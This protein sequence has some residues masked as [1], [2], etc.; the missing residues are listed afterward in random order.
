MDRLPSPMLLR[1]AA[2]PTG[3]GYVFEPKWDGF[4]AIVSTQRGH[5]KVR[6]RRGWE[7]SGLVPELGGLPRGCV[8]D[9]ELV[10]FGDDG[11][12]S[13]PRVCQRVLH[14]NAA[15]PVMFIAFDVL[16]EPGGEL[17][18]HTYSHRRARLEALGI[19][20]AHWST[21]P[22]TGD[23]AMLWQWVCDRGLEGVVAKRVGARYYPGQ[24]RWLK[25]KNRDYWRYPS[26][27]EAAA[28][29][30]TRT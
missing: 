12:P 20:G 21:T 16:A 3:P 6:S 27:L 4:R 25:V 5:P 15:I 11:L 23:G 8:F 30:W 9:G 2:L 7:M 1:S 10:A 14:G 22:V 29:G 18:H 19:H 26:E 28:S 17:L 13:F 24:R